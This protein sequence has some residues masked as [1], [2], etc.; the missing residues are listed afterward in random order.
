VPTRPSSNVASAQ[1]S[2]ITSLNLVQQL[3]LDRLSVEICS[4]LRFASSPLL[5]LLTSSTS[6]HTFQFLNNSC[7]IPI[8]LYLQPLR[9]PNFLLI[10]SIG[11]FG[12]RATSA[13]PV[14]WLP[15][16]FANLASPCSVQ[17][18]PAQFPRRIFFRRHDA[19]FT[20]SK[21]ISLILHGT[22]FY[23]PPLYLGGR[24]TL[25]TL[26]MSSSGCY[27]LENLCN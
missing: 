26:T 9:Y 21:N 11:F 1:W 3:N 15:A 7:F 2:C 23:N 16:I 4:L 24:S 25:L 27:S 18:P 14:T 17:L 5:P 20:T 22:Q 6:F 10:R 8:T 13:E 12:S 19:Q